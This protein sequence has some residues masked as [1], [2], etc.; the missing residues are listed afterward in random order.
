M[1]KNICSALLGICFF[2]LCSTPV[3]ALDFKDGKYEITSSVDMPGMPA[4]AIPPQVTTECMTNKDLI[5]G[6]D[7]V[8]QEC[9]ITKTKQSGD[10][11]TWE[12]EC[13]QE[14]RKMTSTGKMVYKG[15]DFTGNVDI[16]MDTEA[17]PMKMTTKMSGKRVGKCD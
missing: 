16:S 7:V 5:P 4:G 17:G 15:A 11:I 6:K 10:T 9:K 3:M 12:M 13:I 8:G 2:I 1:L 14:G